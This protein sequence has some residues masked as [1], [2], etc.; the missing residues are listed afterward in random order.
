MR[1][2]TLKS[3]VFVAVLA[4]SPL[5]M[6]CDSG[7][8]DP[9]AVAGSVEDNVSS[10]PVQLPVES[11]VPPPSRDVFV[12]ATCEYEAWVGQ[13]LDEAKVKEEGRPYRILKPGDAVTMD[14]N[15]ERINVEHDN[16]KVTRVWCG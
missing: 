10:S 6:A 7:A 15:P 8:E 13:P 16:G 1:L 3:S 11:D 9:A 4:L 5:L 14:M 12:D 2:S